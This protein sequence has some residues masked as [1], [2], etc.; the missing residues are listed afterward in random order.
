MPT[1]ERTCSS[2]TQICFS[3]CATWAHCCRENWRSR[4]SSRTMG[5]FRRMIITTRRS[6]RASAPSCSPTRRPG[7]GGTDQKRA[8]APPCRTSARARAASAG[9]TWS[10]CRGTR[11]RCSERAR[12]TSGRCRTRSPSRRCSTG[13][14]AAGRRRS[15]ASAAKA[16]RTLGST[17]STL[18]RLCISCARTASRSKPSPPRPGAGRI[19][20]TPVASSRAMQRPRSG[21]GR[22]WMWPRARRRR[23]G[24]GF[25]LTASHCPTRLGRR[26]ATSATAASQPRSSRAFAPSGVEA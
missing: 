9:V 10:T 17:A 16:A 2:H 20:R 6:P 12:S 11:T 14:R 15:T 3:T 26:H 18:S 19:I 23:V 8:A 1:A 22:R 4:C 24:A 7:F 21:A 25:R 13:S 5:C